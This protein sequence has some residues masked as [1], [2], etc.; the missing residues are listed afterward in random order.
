[1]EWTTKYRPRTFDQIVG[2]D[3]AVARVRAVVRRAKAGST[4]TPLLLVGPPGTGKTSTAR[5]VAAAL[6]C[7]ASKDEACG[8][9]D[10]CGP[11]IAGRSDL[12]LIQYDAA[13]Y[14][15]VDSIRT[16]R[17]RHL[18]HVVSRGW[19]VLILDEAH[20]VS[21]EGFDALLRPLEEPTAHV[22]FVMAT[23][24]ADAVPA[25]V[26]SRCK[27]MQFGA[28]STDALAQHLQ[29]V[30]AAEGFAPDTGTVEEIARRTN[31][32]VRDAISLLDEWAQVG[33]LPPVAYAAPIDPRTAVRKLSAEL[34]H[35]M[36]PGQAKVAAKLLDAAIKAGSCEITYRKGALQKDAGVAKGTVVAALAWM[37]DNGHV[38]ELDADPE[39]AARWRIL[40]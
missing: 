8:T 10:V 27:V 23:T 24:D 32:Q 2:Q 6:N 5:V 21:P 9:C 28:V 34:R 19:L 40:L 11:I 22:G 29:R 25:A 16:L 7:E 3:A 15:G 12:N 33:T 18:Q 4:M 20:R 31:G 17:D 36:K 14:G 35:S 13:R 38:Q 30:A 1:M 37:V 26:K 39:G